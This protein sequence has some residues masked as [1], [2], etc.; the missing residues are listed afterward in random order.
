MIAN[1]KDQARAAVQVV[2]ALA[3]T[4]RELGEVPNGNLYAHVMGTLSLGEYE[5]VIALLKRA[6]LVAEENHLLR[7]VGPKITGSVSR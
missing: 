7:W 3:E 6:G 1:S 2:A 5:K 4:I